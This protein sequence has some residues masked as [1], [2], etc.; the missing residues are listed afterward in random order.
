MQ[1]LLIIGCGDVALRTI[2]LLTAHYQV[3]ALIRNPARAEALRSMGVMPI[4]GDLDARHSLQKLAGLADIVLH[5]APPPTNQTP[6]RSPFLPLAGESWR[7]GRDTK[8]R[9]TRTQNLLAA[10][11]RGR[12]PT[13]LIYI[14]TS[15]VYGDCAGAWVDETTPINATNPRALRRVNAEQ[16]VRAWATRNQVRASILRVP[17]IYAADRLP[18]DRLR[19][20][21]PAIRSD[22]DSYS[23]HIHADDLARIALATLRYGRANRTYHTTDDE[24]MKMGDYFDA[25]A[26]AFHLPR[27]PRLPRSEVKNLVSPMLWSFMNES[28]R[29]ANQRMKQELKIQLRYPT[30]NS[31][32]AG[33]SL[34][35]PK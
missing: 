21:T 26:D 2:G 22:E 10:L 18:V 23:N 11:S 16:Q 6:S 4:L 29:M 9:D 3:L 27:P 33:A 1:R 24:Q 32:L 35:E 8:N 14:S 28:R 19:A 15:G 12:F 17:G 5:F 7:G 13:Q 20:G 30:L 31:V 25:V 34:G